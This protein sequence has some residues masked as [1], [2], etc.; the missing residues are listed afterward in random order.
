MDHVWTCKCCSKMHY[1]LPFAYAFEGPDA[2]F[3][4]PENDRERRVQRSSDQYVI[5]D[6]EF[7]VRAR[8]EVPVIG[9]CQLF[10]WGVWVSVSEANFARIGDLWEVEIR[11]R[12]PPIFGWLANDFSIYPQTFN[13]KCNLH[14]QN[15]GERPLVAL[16]PT[17]HPLSMEQRKGMTIERVKEIA[18]AVIR[19]S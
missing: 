7:Y 18:A 5:D 14:L 4:I 13:L 12:E 19:H 10:I 16:E 15:A 9:K 3:V 1:T 8:L 17:V 6:K 11:N 2:W